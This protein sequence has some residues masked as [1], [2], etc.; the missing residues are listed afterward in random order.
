VLSINPNWYNASRDIATDVI[1]VQNEAMAAFCAAHADRFAAFA[2]V[3]L[4]FS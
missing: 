1:I 4:Q 2:S 3:A